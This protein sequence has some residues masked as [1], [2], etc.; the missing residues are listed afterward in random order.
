MVSYINFRITAV[1]KI[2]TG[3]VNGLRNKNDF[4]PKTI[5]AKQK[6]TQNA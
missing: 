1:A 5:L 2:Q 6:M 4:L 3:K